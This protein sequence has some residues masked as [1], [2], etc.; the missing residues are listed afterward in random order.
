MTITCKEVARMVSEGLDKKLPPEEQL[1]L[2]AHLAICRGC[3]SISDR[4]AFLRRAVRK[5]VD[6]EDSGTS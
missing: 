1:R 3:R 5:I 4:M 2:R 6:R